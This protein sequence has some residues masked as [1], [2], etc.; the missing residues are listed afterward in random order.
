MRKNIINIVIVLLFIFA[1]AYVEA[2]VISPL[3]RC[4]R[5][6]LNHMIDDVTIH[7]S[8]NLDNDDWITINKDE[9]MFYFIADNDNENLE[10]KFLVS[11]SGTW[12]TPEAHQDPHTF[13]YEPQMNGYIYCQWDVT[14]GT[15]VE[16]DQTITNRILRSYEG[17]Q[18][19]NDVDIYTFL[20]TNSVYCIEMPVNSRVTMSIDLNMSDFSN[21]SFEC[22]T[23]VHNCSQGFTKRCYKDDWIIG[24]KYYIK[25]YCSNS[26]D[27]YEADQNYI[28]T[29]RNVQPVVLIHGINSHPTFPGDP[30]TAFLEIKRVLPHA[31]DLRP[32]VFFDFPW[33]PKNTKYDQY[34]GE[35]NLDKNILYGYIYDILI[36]YKLKP[37]VFSHSMGGI[38]TVCQIE[39]RESIVSLIR[40]YVFFGTPFCGSDAAS[41]PF[42]GFFSNT[43]SDN[44]DRLRRGTKDVWVFMSKI[45]T[46]FLNSYS[47]FFIGTDNILRGKDYGISWHK[48]GGKD[49]DGVVSISSANLSG[50]MHRS[51]ERIKVNYNHTEMKELVFP[52]SG[53]YLDIYNKLKSHIN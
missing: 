23:N 5:F 26:N 3:L 53:D 46:S 19:D 48:N 22:T 52:L 34:I 49:C 29:I 27:Y 4:L 51:N 1:S 16:A 25:L 50:T 8:V 35:N 6:D 10:N 40:N 14:N 39:E 12:P 41:Y 20:P 30:E 28:F 43:S 7:S 36:N 15:P 37:I 13:Q 21:I 33:N 2:E 47:T 38:L 17:I 24:E 11:Y 45:P 44:I 9:N 18:M 31:D 42:A 32:I